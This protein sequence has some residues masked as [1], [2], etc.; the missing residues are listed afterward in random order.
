MSKKKKSHQSINADSGKHNWFTP[1]V[2]IDATRRAM[3]GIDLDPASC[4]RAQEIVQAGMYWT[5]KDNALTKK[6][7]GRVWLNWPYGRKNND[8]WTGYLISQFELGNLTQACALGYASTD[9]GWFQQFDCYWK[10]ML[11]DRISFIDGDTM[12]PVD[13]NPK[14]SCIFYMG[15]NHDSFAESYWDLGAIY[16]PAINARPKFFVQTNMF[17]LLVKE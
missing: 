8:I 10:C 3:G 12:Q 6:W 4:A 13:D 7:F 11:Y 9:T 15:L 14:G 5:I 2:Y 16:P 17:D 1:P